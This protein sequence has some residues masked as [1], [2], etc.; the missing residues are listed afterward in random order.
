MRNDDFA[1]VENIIGYTF[2]DKALLQC[3]LTHESYVN[4]RGGES[5]ERLEFL[6]DS[7]LNFIV[8]EDLYAL[9]DQSEGILTDIRQRIVSKEPLAEA[10]RA[11][12]LLAFYRLGK[13]A[14]LDK[15]NFKDKPISDLFEAVLGAVYIDGGIENARRFVHMHLHVDLCRKSAVK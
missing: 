6:G 1:G 9:C 2:A 4:E 3:A 15:N 12:G 11:M 5:N 14:K 10:V 7:V 8:T 13:G